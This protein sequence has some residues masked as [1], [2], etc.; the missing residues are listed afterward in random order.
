MV[1]LGLET[2]AGGMAR[3]DHYRNAADRPCLS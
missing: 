2:T 3:R 1:L